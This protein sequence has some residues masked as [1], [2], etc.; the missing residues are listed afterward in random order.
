MTTIN[1]SNT[2]TGTTAGQVL[3][4]G[5]AG[6]ASIF[7]TATYPSIAGSSGNVLTSDGT[8]WTS[9]TPSASGD[10][11]G[12]GSSTD[13]ALVRFNGATGKIIQNG[14]VTEDS[15]GNLSQ[16]AAV[17]GTSLSVKTLNTSNT[18]SSTAF[19]QCQVA[20][21][22]ASDAY[23]QA[24]ISGG[25]AWTWGLDNSD[26]DAWVLSATS[27]PGTTN[28][29]RVATSGEI[30]YPLQPAF[31]AYVST[32]ILN[33]TGDGTVYSIIYDVEV[34]DNNGDFNLATSTF[35]A[36]VTGKYKF[37]YMCRLGGGSGLTAALCRLVTSNLTYITNMSQTITTS[38]SLTVGVISLI[39]DMDAGDTATVNVNATDS[40]G[41]V[42]DVAGLASGAAQNILSAYLVC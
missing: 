12:P 27:T 23:Y 33:V 40:G 26:S 37:T 41:K 28:V 17:S 18:A 30:N 39:L 16:S 21:S 10:V 5:G 4:S 3:Q 7:S 24:D 22:T 36:P 2:G 6:S 25:Q 19:H 1:P 35:T 38:S 34:F 13:T 42:D 14:V 29:M 9:A 11:T 8:N 31:L 15:T 32:A 20:G